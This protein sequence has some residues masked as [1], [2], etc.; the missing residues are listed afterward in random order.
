MS[1]G[2]FFWNIARSNKPFEARVSCH[3]LAEHNV[4]HTA[5]GGRKKKK[6]KRVGGTTITTVLSRLLLIPPGPPSFRERRLAGRTLCGCQ[7]DVPFLFSGELTQ[8][9]L[10]PLCS[11]RSFYSL[12]SHSHPPVLCGRARL[13]RL[14][15]TYTQYPPLFAG[16]SLLFT[17]PPLNP[18]PS[19]QPCAVQC[20]AGHSVDRASPSVL[21]LTP[22]LTVRPL[23]ERLRRQAVGGC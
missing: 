14:L 20:T 11:V 13:W 10:G 23:K 7:T 12:G 15:R 4:L 18:T 22:P 17:T 16:S 3:G 8:K 2:K 1:E 5:V 9:Y 19:S 21:V 6:K